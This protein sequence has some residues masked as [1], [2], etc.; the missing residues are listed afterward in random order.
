MLL[1]CGIVKLSVASRI[2]PFRKDMLLAHRI[3]TGW[4]PSWTCAA[5]RRY[6]VKQAELHQCVQWTQSCIDWRLYSWTVE[7]FVFIV[8][9]LWCCLTSSVAWCCSVEL[10]KKYSSSNTTFSLCFDA[11]Q[12]CALPLMTICAVSPQKSQL[13]ACYN[14]YICEPIWIIFYRFVTEKV[15]SQKMIYI[16]TSPN[17]CFCTTLQN[18]KAGKLIFSLKYWCCFVSKHTKHIK[19]FAWTTFIFKTIDC[20]L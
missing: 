11:Y 2:Q 12:L 3:M 14:F 9:I 13:F 8:L 1:F 16:L 20:V 5:T 17:W 15:S 10:S 7:C 4:V 19:I 6:P 18:R